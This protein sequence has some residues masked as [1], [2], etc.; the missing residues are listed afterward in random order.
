MME[1]NCS[2]ET[3]VLTRA[4]RC[5]ISEDGILQHFLS[6]KMSVFT[7]FSNYTNPTR[8]EQLSLGNRF[9]KFCSQSAT[10][11]PGETPV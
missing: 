5:N 1:A 4:T 10:L 6:L 2:S 11:T 7:A 9:G 3:S 8:H